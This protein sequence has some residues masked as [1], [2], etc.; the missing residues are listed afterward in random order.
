MSTGF[1]V[2]HF[3]CS[4]SASTFSIPGSGDDRNLFYMSISPWAFNFFP[5]LFCMF[6]TAFT[7]GQV[8]I[9][10]F[11]I[12]SYRVPAF[13]TTLIQFVH[14]AVLLV[15]YSPSPLSCLP[16]C[17]LAFLVL[18]ALRHVVYYFAFY[19]VLLLFV[20]FVWAFAVLGWSLKR[21][22]LSP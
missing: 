15:L 4:K 18:P 5:L 8:N 21:L 2:L 11:N 3:K 1:S 22:L 16:R 12:L 6:F 20:C 17:L 10:S 7:P 19:F 14:Y 13:P 9:L